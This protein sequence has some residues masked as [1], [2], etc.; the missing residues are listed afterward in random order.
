MRRA[1]TA[2][3]VMGMAFS[4]QGAE[5]GPISFPAFTD[6]CFS[7]S[8]P[9]STS[10]SS[11]TDLGT[12]GNLFPD[13]T[14]PSTL[15]TESLTELPPLTLQD[16]EVVD[17]SLNLSLTASGSCDPSHPCTPAVVPEPGSLLLLGSGLTALAARLR[18]RRR[19]VA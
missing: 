15:T 1:A 18:N 5:A 9:C 11:P 17:L 6:P 12:L 8:S 14:L 3:L 16:L 4:A 19:Q 13:T 7:T 10:T 2:L